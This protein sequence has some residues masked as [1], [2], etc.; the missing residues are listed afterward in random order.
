MLQMLTII[1]FVTSPA[2]WSTPTVMAANQSESFKGFN[3][4][5]RDFFILKVQVQSFTINIT[6]V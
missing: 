5:L 4:V 6:V 3:F 1:Y 2:L